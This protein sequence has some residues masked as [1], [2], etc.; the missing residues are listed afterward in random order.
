VGQEVEHLPSKHEALNSIFS[1]EKKIKYQMK[2]ALFQECYD[3]IK[4]RYNPFK[5]MTVLGG[6]IIISPFYR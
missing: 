4:L 3:Y 1:T 6:E 2:G 5:L